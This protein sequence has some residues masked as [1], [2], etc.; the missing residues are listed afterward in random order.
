MQAGHNRHEDI[1]ES[2]DLFGTEVLP[3][4]IERDEADAGRPS[5][6]DGSR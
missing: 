6:R 4:F 2:I 1:M 5:R 3:E